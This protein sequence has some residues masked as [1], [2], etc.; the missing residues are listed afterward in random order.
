MPHAVESQS[1]L[2]LPQLVEQLER[3]EADT[4]RLLGPAFARRLQHWRRYRDDPVRLAAFVR[5]CLYR[6]SVNGWALHQKGGLSLEAIAIGF[7][8]P[9]FTRQDVDHAR[10]TLGLGLSQAVVAR[11]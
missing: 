7:G 11:R 1:T 3:C 10:G 9:L 5:D 6:T 4:L 2:A 8:P